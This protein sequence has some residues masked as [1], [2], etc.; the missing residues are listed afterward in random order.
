MRTLALIEGYATRLLKCETF[1]LR[2]AGHVVVVHNAFLVVGA[3]CD[4]EAELS[5]LCVVII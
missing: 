1:A 5:M 2:A 3:S 4:C